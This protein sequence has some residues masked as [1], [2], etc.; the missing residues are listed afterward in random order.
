MMMK[1]HLAIGVFLIAFL[2]P[3]IN[4]KLIFCVVVL[5]ASLLPDIDIAN[6]YLGQKKIFRPLQW[7]VK[8]RGM[9]HSFTL[10][11]IVS[12]MF[13][14]YIPILTLPFFLGY[15][16]HLLADSFTVEGI[17]PFWPLKKEVEGSI[18]VSGKREMLILIMILIFSALLFVKW[19][20]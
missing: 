7:V 12:F 16:F 5:V 1:T 4:N 10:C 14:Y 8:H 18:R 11:L 9:I 2:L 17:R 6:S 19:F 3:V 13:A 20:I 15:S